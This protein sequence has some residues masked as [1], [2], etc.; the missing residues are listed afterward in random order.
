MPPTRKPTTHDD[1]RKKVCL[2]CKKKGNQMRV[3]SCDTLACFLIWVYFIEDY[4]PN[5]QFS[6]K[7]GFINSVSFYSSHRAAAVNEKSYV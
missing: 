3:L 2:I 5:D 1:N 6:L 4:D 7:F